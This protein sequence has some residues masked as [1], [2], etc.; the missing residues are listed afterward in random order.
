MY[1]RTNSKQGSEEFEMKY[2]LSLYTLSLS[3]NHKKEFYISP[4]DKKIELSVIRFI[5]ENPEQ[6]IFWYKNLSHIMKTDDSDPLRNVISPYAS[7]TYEPPRGR[8]HTVVNE[9]KEMSGGKIAF[10]GHETTLTDISE[11]LIKHDSTVESSF[12]QAKYDLKALSIDMMD[13]KQ[14]FEKTF[15]SHK[16][17]PK[18]L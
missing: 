2:D 10:M 12:K 9:D 16:E 15:K 3:K 8:S 7:P 1:I 17:G 14:D 11:F 5:A 13:M 4:S 18:F 6:R